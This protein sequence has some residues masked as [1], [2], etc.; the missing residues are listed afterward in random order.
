MNEGIF[1]VFAKQYAHHTRFAGTPR[2]AVADG[3]SAVD[4]MLSA[5]LT[6]SGQEPSR[7]HN[8]K[9]ETA[10][11]AFAN[12]FAAESVQLGHGWSF[13]PGADWKSL[14]AYHDE[15]LASCYEKFELDPDVSV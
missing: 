11:K 5:L 4:A 12:A 7:N 9:F 6:H 3:Y 13:A 2:Q 1:Y 15:W 14:E 10:R 8:T